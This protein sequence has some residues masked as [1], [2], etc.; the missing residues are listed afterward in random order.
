MQ[1]TTEQRSEAVAL[2]EEH[3]PAEASRRTGI[4]RRTITSWREP[5]QA[6]AKKTEAAR[7]ANTWTD[8]RAQEALAAGSAAN[9]MRR[10]TLDASTEGNHQLLRARVIAYGIFIDK[11]EALSGAASERIAVWA[12]S[13][14]DRDLREA[15]D[16]LEDR[17]RDGD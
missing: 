13:E 2:A 5:A 8:F 14:I 4:P 1:Y 15:L 7:I 3:G 10:E 17:I 16:Q 6:D 11:A 9:R 12:E